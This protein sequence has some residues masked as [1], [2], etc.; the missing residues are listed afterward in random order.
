MY[1]STNVR[2]NISTKIFKCNF[3]NQYLK[4]F[5]LNYNIFAGVGLSQLSEQDV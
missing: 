5:F 3:G 1:N 4:T 2:V